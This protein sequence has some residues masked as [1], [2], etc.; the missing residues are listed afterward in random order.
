MP[1][2]VDYEPTPEEIRKATAEIRRGWSV[3]KKVFRNQLPKETPYKTPV[4]S[5]T[6][7]RDFLDDTPVFTRIN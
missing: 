6:M 1:R 5:V 7:V 4:Y 2:K 3:S